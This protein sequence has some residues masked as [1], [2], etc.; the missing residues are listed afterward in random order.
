ME[1]NA[2]IILIS[3]WDY[4][5]H[6]GCLPGHPIPRKNKSSNTVHM[7]YFFIRSPHQDIEAQLQAESDEARDTITSL[8]ESVAEEKR[9]REEAEQDI[10]KHKRV[11]GAYLLNFTGR[12]SLI[13][14]NYLHVF[15]LCHIGLGPQ[16]VLLGCAR[17]LQPNQKTI[18]NRAF[19]S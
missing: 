1:Q 15:F 13:F 9:R 14:K 18:C 3:I 16:I 8:E 11:G 5:S 19:L 12:V 7:F 10:L 17:C 4:L 2:F 6:P